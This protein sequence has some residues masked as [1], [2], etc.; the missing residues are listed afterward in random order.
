VAISIS[1]PTGKIKKCAPINS[2]IVFGIWFDAVELQLLSFVGVTFMVPIHFFVFQPST[3]EETYLST[4][5]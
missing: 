3:R 4:L 2:S 1:G 5:F